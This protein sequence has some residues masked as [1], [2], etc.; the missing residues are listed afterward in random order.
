MGRKA[1]IDIPGGLYHVIARGNERGKIFREKS[2]YS[3]FLSRLNLG[4]YLTETGQKCLSWACIPNH[5]FNGGR[6]RAA[7]KIRAVYCFLSREKRG[8]KGRDLMRE[9]GL[10]SGA[11]SH[12]CGMGRELVGE[13]N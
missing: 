3:E 8:L 13:N 6:T 12:L 5:F 7:V 10:S 2:D 9:P 11:I 4:R 1:R